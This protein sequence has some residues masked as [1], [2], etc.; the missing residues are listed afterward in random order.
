MQRRGAV[1]LPNQQSPFMSG[2]VERPRDRRRRHQYERVNQIGSNIATTIAHTAV[3]EPVNGSFI[4]STS[5]GNQQNVVIAFR[6]ETPPPSYFDIVA[7]K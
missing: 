1:M 5:E 2:F 4:A 7:K 6:P 3:E